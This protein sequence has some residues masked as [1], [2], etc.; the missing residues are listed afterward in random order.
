MFNNAYKKVEIIDRINLQLGWL[1]YN[2][3]G[4]EP[5]YFVVDTCTNY[6]H[7]LEVY[8]WKE[9]KDN[10]P[11]DGNDHMINSTQYGWIPYRDKIG[12]KRNEGGR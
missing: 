1:S 6:I 3:K 11:E 9:D 5:S 4:K 12:V 8:S 7:E 2:D 10:E